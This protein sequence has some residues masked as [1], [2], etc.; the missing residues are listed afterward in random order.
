[1]AKLKKARVKV[2][3]ATHATEMGMSELQKLM[4]TQV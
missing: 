4:V 2:Q 3:S 1:M